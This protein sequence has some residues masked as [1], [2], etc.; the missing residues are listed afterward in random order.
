MVAVPFTRG[1][2]GLSGAVS[3]AELVDAREV[4]VSPR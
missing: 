1:R 3:G 4:P 2:R